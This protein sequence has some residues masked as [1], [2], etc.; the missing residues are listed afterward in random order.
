MTTDFF[1]LSLNFTYRNH[2]RTRQFNYF[3]LH[4]YV[5]VNFIY[6]MRKTL[7]EI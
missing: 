1:Q 7:D 5:L 3:L 6:L 4:G 2:C